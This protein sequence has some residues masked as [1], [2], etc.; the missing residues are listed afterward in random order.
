MRIYATMQR[1]TSIFPY[2]I[3]EGKRNIQRFWPSQRR[4][5]YPEQYVAEYKEMW[6]WKI[7]F[8]TK[9]QGRGIKIARV[10]SILLAKPLIYF[11]IV[12]AVAR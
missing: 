1:F 6:K 7:K 5:R 4:N 8:F 9:F 11:N 2:L 10:N 3:S 12:R